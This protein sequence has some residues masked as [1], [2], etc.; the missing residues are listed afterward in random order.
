MPQPS[1][2]IVFFICGLSVMYYCMSAWILWVKNTMRLFRYLAVLLIVVAVQGIVDLIVIPFDHSF[3]DFAWYASMA[4]DIMSL[5]LYNTVIQ[6]LTK[7]GSVTVRF[8]GWHCALFAVFPALLMITRMPLFYFLELGLTAVYFMVYAVIT[9]RNI[10]RYNTTMRE[11]FSYEENVNLHWLLYITLAVLGIFVIW[12]VDSFGNGI[13]LQA[14]C[15]IGSLLCWIML[16]R[17]VYLHESIIDELPQRSASEAEPAELPDG[18]AEALRKKLH[19][20]FHDDHIFLNPRLKLGDVASLAG[21]NRTYVS[22]FFNRTSGSTF[23]EYVN[24]LRVQY[25]CQ[26][27][28]TSSAPLGEIAEMSGF[29]S[30]ATFHRVFS[31]MR[32]CSP[33]A[34]RASAQKPENKR[35]L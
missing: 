16:T 24:Q 9:I 4:F 17:F 10:R 6:E 20:L 19:A 21:T 8:I 3:G 29:N 25:A 11:R 28:S 22:Q 15:M 13:D 12:L 27:L 26:L 35:N 34:F 23:F 14:F 32:G 7:P 18:S 31:R 5:P 33:A 1:T 2:N 30:L